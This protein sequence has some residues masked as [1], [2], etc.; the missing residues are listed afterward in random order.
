MKSWIDDYL[1][2]SVCDTE[3][4]LANYTLLKREESNSCGGDAASTA[5]HCQTLSL[6]SPLPL[7]IVLDDVELASVMDMEEEYSAYLGKKTVCPKIEDDVISRMI[8]IDRLSY[9]GSVD[10]TSRLS[11]ASLFH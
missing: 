11:P 9:S 2:T 8:Y 5:D 6:S 3:G 1:I 7:P 10:Q 4:T